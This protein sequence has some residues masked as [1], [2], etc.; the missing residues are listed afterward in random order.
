MPAVPCGYSVKSAW[1]G[2]ASLPIITTTFLRSGTAAKTPIVVTGVSQA[3]GL[4]LSQC[5]LFTLSSVCETTCLSAAAT[6]L[7]FQRC[8]LTMSLNAGKGR[9]VC[10]EGTCTCAWA[11]VDSCWSNPPA[12]VHCKVGLK[13][14][15]LSIAQVDL[16]QTTDPTSVWSWWLSAACRCLSGDALPRRRWMTGRSCWQPATRKCRESRKCSP[17]VLFPRKKSLHV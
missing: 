9:N 8:Q 10:R 16:G 1:N 7:T 4:W 2:E 12:P 11:T 14:I 3:S 15:C 5:P 13:N 6:L 17:F